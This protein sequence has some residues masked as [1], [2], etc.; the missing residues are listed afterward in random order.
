MHPVILN[1][2]YS[3]LNLYLHNCGCRGPS[4]KLYVIFQLYGWLNLVSSVL[5]K[6]H[7]C[8]LD[9]GFLSDK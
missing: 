8:I 2:V 7:L 1:T 6:G 3:W 9:T 5:F 4:V